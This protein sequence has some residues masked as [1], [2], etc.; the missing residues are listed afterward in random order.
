MKIIAS[1]HKYLLHCW[2][3]LPAKFKKYYDYL[4][5]EEQC[6]SVFFK[7]RGWWY[8]LN[9]FMNLRYN[10]SPIPEFKGWDGYT[11]DTYFSGV[12]VKWYVDKYTGEVDPD[13]V[14]VGIFCS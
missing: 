2:H 9:D 10:C 5:E 3:D 1:T 7:Y 13:Y 14:Q 11:N 4:S 8:N 6:D 12:L